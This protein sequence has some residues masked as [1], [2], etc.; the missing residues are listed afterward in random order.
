MTLYLEGE[1]KDPEDGRI[2]RKHGK[3]SFVDLAGSERVKESNAQGETLTE[4][5]NINKSL[6]TLGKCISALSD[7]KK[8]AGHIPYRDS[9]LT[10]LLSDSLGGHGLALMVACIS[11]AVL[12]LTE[13]VKTLRYAQRAKKIKNKPVV[14]LDPREEM[15]MMLRKEIQHLRRENELMKEAIVED[16]RYEELLMFIAQGKH[17]IGLPDVTKV[18]SSRTSVYAASPT[19]SGSIRSEVRQSMDS[20]E[21]RPIQGA[22]LSSAAPSRASLDRHRGGKPAFSSFSRG[23]VVQSGRQRPSSASS[24]E[25]SVSRVSRG[26]RASVS[27]R[28]GSFRK[29]AAAGS[30]NPPPSRSAHASAAGPPRWNTKP[31]T[32]GST[33]RPVSS[34]SRN[35]PQQSTPTSQRI[36]SSAVAL[37]KSI[38]SDNYDSAS[39]SEYED[40]FVAPK[41]ESPQSTLPPS[42]LPQQM[43]K[44]PV[45][46]SSVPPIAK[47]SS[48]KSRPQEVQP[49]EASPPPPVKSE[50]AVEPKK[51]T[52][53]SKSSE[54][55]DIMPSEK[56]K[57]KSNSEEKSK[58]SK[59]EKVAR[60]ETPETVLSESEPEQKPAVSRKK[61]LPEE[62]KII[63]SSRGKTSS[64]P[65]KR[66]DPDDSEGNHSEEVEDIVRKVK[67]KKRVSQKESGIDDLP[68]IASTTKSSRI[69]EGDPSMTKELSKLKKK[70]MRDVEALDVEIQK[71]SQK[72]KPR[73]VE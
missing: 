11:P 30:R 2:I 10:K 54:P 33:S 32:S 31:P 1:F 5:L 61:D 53:V 9:K 21:M 66:A 8:R 55:A 39:E 60:S 72:T 7:A 68:P 65:K 22:R 6:L 41:M 45:M 51:A 48:L 24:M 38:Y 59:K 69:K 57:K 58:V 26:S 52:K 70:T 18:K 42:I 46:E 14:N 71:L 73:I 13:T 43:R 64:K 63:K 35:H 17:L 34:F 3:I 37:Q 40:K 49:P 50:E 15:L 47:K 56:L 25:S 67:E 16:P 4:T 29:E 62:D 28:I 20:S 23:P 12:N 44:E 27:S 19:R 36:P